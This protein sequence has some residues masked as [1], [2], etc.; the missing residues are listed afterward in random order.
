MDRG[1]GTV[2]IVGAGIVGV[3][4]ALALLNAGRPVRLIDRVPPGEGCSFGN[5]AVIT[6]GSVEPLALPGVMSQVPAWL[7]DPE[8]PLV[9]RWGHL[10]R[11]LP[12][13]WRFLK[14]AGP[15]RVRAVAAAQAALLRGS[16]AAHR[17]LAEAA[18][19]G[20]MIRPGGFLYVYH[21]QRG[22][23]ADRGIWALRRAQG[24]RV[25]ALEGPRL[26][27][28]EPGLGSV[29]GQGLWMPDDAWV[30][31]PAG[32]VRG[33]AAEVRRRGGRI[34]C[35]E[36]LGLEPGPEAPRRLFTSIGDIPVET[37][38]IAAGAHSGRLA[39]LLG[40]RFPLE[41]ERGY[42][43]QVPPQAVSGRTL[44]SRPVMWAE[45]RMVATPVAGGLRLAGTAEFAGLS[46][47][48]D[49][50]RAARFL[51]WGRTLLPGLPGGL[52]GEA[53]RWMG[54]RPTL[55]DTLPVIGRSSRW[56]RV[57]YAFGHGHT[58]L[59]AGPLTGR[60]IA[61]QIAGHRPPIDPAPYA[62]GRFTG[63]S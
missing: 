44:V 1:T 39:A 41:S 40:E 36:V 28:L 58:G 46:A 27:E 42:H 32:L 37:L 10:P 9:V 7:L 6:E 2:T 15:A 20:E 13:F 47:P 26:A 8:G 29:F 60:L 33:L 62:P 52:D 63:Q 12:F 48:P 30:I 18:G 51:E 49:F 24:V 25:E 17:G 38:L 16:V 53:S 59:T 19:V 31:S 50:A 54:H 4:A 11:A 57:F 3:S 43:L 22:L 55:P 14:A 23:A 61:A 21:G 35:A 45:R 34:E 56:R 5:A